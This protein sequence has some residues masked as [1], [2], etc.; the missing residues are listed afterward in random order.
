MYQVNIGVAV[1]NV[2]LRQVVKVGD[3][4]FRIVYDDELDGNNKQ[5]ALEMDE[6]DGNWCTVDVGVTPAL[7][8]G[9]GRVNSHGSYRLGNGVR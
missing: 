1:I 5:L 4:K 6:G 7:C 2:G 9:N 3:D 8:Y